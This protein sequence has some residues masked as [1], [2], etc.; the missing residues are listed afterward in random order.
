MYS[1]SLSILSL[2]SNTQPQ[3]IVHSVFNHYARVRSIL[4]H[5][6]ELDEYS[7]FLE[8]EFRRRYD[9]DNTDAHDINITALSPEGQE[10][11]PQSSDKSN[12]PPNETNNRPVA[13]KKKS[14]SSFD[15]DFISSGPPSSLSP[16]TSSRN[17]DPTQYAHDSLLTDFVGQVSGST[18][19]SNSGLD[20][21]T[22]S[23]PQKPS[24]DP[25]IHVEKSNILL[26]GPTGIYVFSTFV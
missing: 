24:P 8:A 3:T 4:R 26:V 25:M 10:Q 15:F 20:M 17:N 21:N 1:F 9:N 23:F 11:Q 2:Y 13:T 18:S 5:S 7:R 12:A 22:I 16:S 6:E 19:S 14:T